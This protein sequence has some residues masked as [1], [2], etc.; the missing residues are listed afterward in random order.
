MAFTGIRPPIEDQSNE[1]VKRAVFL[2][3]DGTIIRNFLEGETYAPLR[4]LD[5]FEILPSVSTAIDLLKS[6]SFLPIV[7]TN[8][9]DLARGTVE[10]DFVT[11]TNK[12]LEMELGIKHFY[13][14]PHDDQHNCPCRKPKPGMILTAAEDLGLSIVDSYLVGDS[15]KD[16]AAANSAGCSAFWIRNPAPKIPNGDF[17]AVNS[18]YEAALEIVTNQ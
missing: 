6:N 17:R 7:V 8:Q 1:M 2:D 10:M 3:R 13:V 15:W 9:P 14:C 12:K 16:I 18:L 4:T 5:Q 11:S